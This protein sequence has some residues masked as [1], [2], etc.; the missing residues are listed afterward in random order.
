MNAWHGETELA[1]RVISQNV[2]AHDNVAKNRHKNTEDSLHRIRH[3][4]IDHRQ[5]RRNEEKE[6]E[7]GKEFLMFSQ[8]L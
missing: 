3:D 6:R 8:Y 2:L 7:K 1:I 4:V 5:E